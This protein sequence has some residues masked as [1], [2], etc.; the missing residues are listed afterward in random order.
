MAASDFVRVT[1]TIR[2]DQKEWLDEDPATNLSG[3]V[4]QA[5]DAR[6]ER[7]KE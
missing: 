5:I 7:V 1:V 2:K 4:Q 6:R 3:L